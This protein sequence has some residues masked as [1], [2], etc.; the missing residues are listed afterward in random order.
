MACAWFD[1]PSWAVAAA[2]CPNACAEANAP[3]ADAEEPGRNA[4]ANDPIPEVWAW[5]EPICSSCTPE[6]DTLTL[7]RS[8]IPV[9]GSAGPTVAAVRL[10]EVV[11][12]AAVPPRVAAGRIWRRL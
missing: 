6:N 1:F 8:M 4:T 3:S 9:S 5:A 2:A 7:N 10:C 12:S 11:V